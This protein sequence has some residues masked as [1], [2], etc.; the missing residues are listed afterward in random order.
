MVPRSIYDELGLS[1]GPADRPKSLSDQAW[2][3]GKVMEQTKKKL[4]KDYKTGSRKIESRVT[5]SSVEDHSCS[6]CVIKKPSPKVKGEAAKMKAMDGGCTEDCDKSAGTAEGTRYDKGK[7]LGSPPS[8]VPRA[9]GAKPAPQKSRSLSPPSAAEKSNKKSDKTAYEEF[10]DDPKNR[11]IDKIIELETAERGA[12]QKSIETQREQMR[13]IEASGGD[14]D[15]QKGLKQDLREWRDGKN[16]MILAP[17]SE[18]VKLA[19]AMGENPEA[20]KEQLAAEKKRREDK[21]K[22]RRGSQLEAEE[23]EHAK[24][25]RYLDQ[26][27]WKFT[28]IAKWNEFDEKVS[29]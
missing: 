23:R 20:V 3:G 26:Q 13:K 16:A 1:W 29:T 9:K 14:S 21:K 11:S 8:S 12:V 28:R 10:S 5:F 4:N 2:G 19:I 18:Q 27:T 6:L 22:G 25:G 24:L 17:N 7:A 15:T